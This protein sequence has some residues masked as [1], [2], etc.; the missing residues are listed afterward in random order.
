MKIYI[1]FEED[2]FDKKIV[3][4]FLNKKDAENMLEES[5]DDYNYVYKIEEHKVV[6]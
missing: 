4:V 2:A 6:K 5:K 1:L 3:A